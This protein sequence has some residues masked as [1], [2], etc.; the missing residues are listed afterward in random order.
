MA[1]DSEKNYLQLV[2]NHKLTSAVTWYRL[3]YTAL[4]RMSQSQSVVIIEVL[5]GKSFYRRIAVAG[6]KLNIFFI[7]LKPAF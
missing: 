5:L 7:I 4:A 1:C 2:I 6:F 3:L